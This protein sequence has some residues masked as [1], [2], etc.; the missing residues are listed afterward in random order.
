VVNA[1][2][3]ERHMACVT[4]LKNSILSHQAPQRITRVGLWLEKNA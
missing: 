3:P 2:D 4:L 1:N